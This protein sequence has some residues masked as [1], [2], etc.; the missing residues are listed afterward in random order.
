VGLLVREFGKSQR[1]LRGFR[2][3]TLA[4]GD[5]GESAGVIDWDGKDTSGRRLPDGLYL[6]RLVS[7]DHTV[8]CKVVFAR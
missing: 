4:S 7:G 1:R 5:M 8:T 3:R 2:V 6:V